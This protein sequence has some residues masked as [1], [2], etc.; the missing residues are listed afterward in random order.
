MQGERC[1]MM[2]DVTTTKKRKTTNNYLIGIFS[3]SLQ[4]QRKESG[5]IFKLDYEKAYDRVDRIFLLK[6]LR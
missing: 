1:M 3:G 5:F 6:M 2:Q 4:V